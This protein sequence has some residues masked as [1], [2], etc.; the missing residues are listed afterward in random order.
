MEKKVR[1]SRG[2]LIMRTSALAVTAGLL[3]SSLAACSKGDSGNEAERH[4]LRIGFMYSNSDNEPYLR[5]QFTDGYEL[6]HPNIDIE[7]AAA[8]NYDDQRFE[9]PD[10]N[11]KQP[12]PYEKLKEMINGKNPV[13]VVV[14]ESSYLKRLVED[15]LLKQLDPL[16]QESEFDIEDFVPTVI[17]GIKDAGGGSLYAL[18]PTFNASALYY[19][20]K[21][22]T[23]AGV[24]PPTD[25]MTWTDILT[26]AKQVAKGE[27]AERKF[28]FSFNRWSGDPFWDSQ[29]YSAPLQLK[30]FDNKA[31]KMT[32]D[33][34]QWR[35]VWSEVAGLYQEKIVP[36]QEDMNNGGGGI[37]RDKDAAFNPFQND[38]FISGRIAM[39]IGGYDYVNELSRAKDY[40][41]KNPKI[42]SPDWDVVT[43]PT[44]EE[45]PGVGG[46]I[47]LNNLMAISA[48]AQNSD[49][50]WDFI[51]FNNS[52]EW[53]KLKSRSTYEMVARKSFLKPKDGMN[54]NI[55]A[56][57]TLKPIPPQDITLE[58]LYREKPNLYQVQQF[59]QPLFQEVI[60]KK[61][62][63]EEALKEWQTKGDAMLQKIKDNPN[64]PLEPVDGGGGVGINVYGGKG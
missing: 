45:A 57:Y 43:I 2:K 36:T 8:I 14:L 6:T 41:A 48:N 5:Q 54:Y 42:P 22:F 17:D 9:E 34:P 33:T 12:D 52:K 32:V 27:G 50:A 30:M 7:I 51:Q 18:T 29:T 58:K 55:E 16:I 47:Y 20:K 64:G 62:S 25:G 11:K 13:D 37:V 21:L 15:N 61:K 10:P 24:T 39:M 26:K 40:A 60:Q 53:A 19:N 38:L 3:A 44:F 46:S 35:K 63:V 28:G 56:F 23:D 31:E 59:A 1:R 49:D 4:V